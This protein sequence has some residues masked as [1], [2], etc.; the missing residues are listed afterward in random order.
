MNIEIDTDK[1]RE[2]GN[3]ILNEANNYKTNIDYLK[4][5]I[6]NINPK[7]CEWI[8]S[9]ALEFIDKFNIDYNKYNDVYILF[10]EYG[11]YLID[12]SNKIDNIIKKV[13]Y[14]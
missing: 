4:N 1:L 11:N 12:C 2:I 10:K 14:D 8:G 7:T 5:R 6:N 9:S 13:F 3:D